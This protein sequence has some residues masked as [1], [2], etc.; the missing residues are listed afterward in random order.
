MGDAH[1]P[2]RCATAGVRLQPA[3]RL[4]HIRVPGD[5]QL[6]LPRP[7]P[8]RGT[9]TKLPAAALAA[10]AAATPLPSDGSYLRPSWVRLR[11]VS[12]QPR[13]RSADVPRRRRW[14]L[15]SLRVTQ[16]SPGPTRPAGS[17]ERRA[18]VHT[19]RRRGRRPSVRVS[20]GGRLARRWQRPL[21][22][23]ACPCDRLPHP[24]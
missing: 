12:L 17:G 10:A 7:S 14:P 5:T 24:L 21:L 3:G 6:L 18:G 16:F 15:R 4:P 13:A 9:N 1:V 2:S 22:T 23:T 11:S 19:W 8:P 20:A